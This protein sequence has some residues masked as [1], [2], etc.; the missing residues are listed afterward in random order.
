MDTIAVDGTVLRQ[1]LLG[2][3]R[4]YSLM[5]KFLPSK[6]ATRVRF[7]LPARSSKSFVQSNLSSG[8]LTE[9]GN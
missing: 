7:P 2:K 5:V 9:N 6:Q 8:I 1:I 4:G 3:L